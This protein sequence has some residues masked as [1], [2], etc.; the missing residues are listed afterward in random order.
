MTKKT[1]TSRLLSIVLCLCMVLSIL[2]ATALNAFAA[3]M[4]GGE[5]LYLKPNSN[6][7][8]ADARFAAYFFGSGDAWESMTEVSP[9]Q[10]STKSQ[11]PAAA[12]HM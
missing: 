4:T 2:P 6:W 7:A 8:S 3:T 10:G 11:C 1:F 5:V 9:S 12:G